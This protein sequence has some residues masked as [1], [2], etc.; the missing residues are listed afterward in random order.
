LVKNRDKKNILKC[1]SAFSSQLSALSLNGISS[2]VGHT[3]AFVKIQDGCDNFC[4][5][6]KVPLVRGRS[7][8]RPKEEIIAEV[9]RLVDNGFKEIVL[10][11]ICLGAY[12]DLCGLIG[13]LE[14]IKGLLRI[15]LSSIEAVDVSDSLINKMSKSDK[16][17]RHLHIPIQSGDDEILKKMNRK[18][19][20][21]QYLKLIKK[22][23]RKIPG[24]AITTDVLVGFP[25]ESEKNF[26]N[27]FDLIKRIAPLKVHIFPYS[28]RLG[29]AAAGFKGQVK[30][31]IIKERIKRLKKL[32]DS[33]AL[34][35]ARKFLGKTIPVLFEAEI[36]NKLN[37]WQGYTD[38]YIQVRLKSSVN[39]KNCIKPVRLAK[40]NLVGC[41]CAL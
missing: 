25:G 22:I 41:K 21:I 16:L 32:S 26:S 9:R 19:N 7:A 24:I 28:A 23:R 11:G 10:T 4:S 33:C 20:R 17:C 27:T 40:T 35:Y 36:E 37:C 34:S 6:C 5:Y 38:N 14:K 30:A 12:H 15:R 18:Y 2:F 13:G 1:F 29:T 39:L 8:S 31:E 3:R